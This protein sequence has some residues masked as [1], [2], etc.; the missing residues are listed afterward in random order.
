MTRLPVIGYGMTVERRKH[1]AA[2]RAEAYEPAPTGGSALAG[3]CGATV[4]VVA[5]YLVGRN[6]GWRLEDQPVAAV[7]IVGAGFIAG[8]VG[9]RRARERNRMAQIDEM[10]RGPDA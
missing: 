4:A 5:V 6:Y 3:F 10:E 9:Y 8:F 1:E 2:Q 7:L